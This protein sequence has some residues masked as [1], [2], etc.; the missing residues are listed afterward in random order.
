MTSMVDAH[1]GQKGQ[2][3]LLVATVDMVKR[4]IPDVR[5]QRNGDDKLR[6]LAEMARRGMQLISSQA[7]VKHVEIQKFKW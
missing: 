7:L 5:K 2:P 6:Q 1:I 4:W 3:S